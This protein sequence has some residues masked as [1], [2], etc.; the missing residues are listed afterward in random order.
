M[1]VFLA[2]FTLGLILITQ[3][4]EA[5]SRP[6]QRPAPVRVEREIQAALDFWHA[7]GVGLDQDY[8]KAWVTNDLTGTDVPGKQVDGRGRDGVIWLLSSMVAKA[9]QGGYGRRRIMLSRKARRKEGVPFVLGYD[10]ERD[11]VA[12]KRREGWVVFHEVGH[13]LGLPHTEHGLMA[14]DGGGEIP[15]PVLVMFHYPSGF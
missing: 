10:S 5:Y 2:F 9:N 4:A 8:V 6:D 15:W 12:A 3:N 14:P 11:G 7:R 13:A 1:K